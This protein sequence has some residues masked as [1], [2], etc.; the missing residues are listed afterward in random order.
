MLTKLKENRR[1]CTLNV[2]P[3]WLLCP[4]GF[5]CK[6]TGVGSHSFSRGSFPPRDRTWV[7]CSV[8]RHVTIWATRENLPFW[9]LKKMLKLVA[10]RT[11]TMLCNPEPYLV[12]ELSQYPKWRLHTHWAL[13]LTSFSFISHFSRKLEVS[14]GRSHW[15][16]RPQRGMEFVAVVL[17][18]KFPWTRLLWPQWQQLTLGKQESQC[19]WTGSYWK[20]S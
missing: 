9:P 13:T 19:V 6:N 17:F 11:F 8:G 2:H 3:S 14:T 10:L 20:H 12:P 4:W 1:K 7:S 5:P 18:Q 15:L 16:W